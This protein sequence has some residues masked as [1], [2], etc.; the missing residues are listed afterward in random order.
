MGLSFQRSQVSGRRRERSGEYRQYF[1]RVQ[2]RVDAPERETGFFDGIDITMAGI[3]EL[4]RGEAPDGA[5]ELLSG[6]D[7][8]VADAIAAYSARNPAAVVPFLAQGLGAT[9]EAMRLS[10]GSAEALF[11]L[12]I[13]ERQFQ[14]AISA[15]MGIQFRAVASPRD[16]GAPQSPFAPLATM[17]PAVPGEPFQVDVSLVN[18]GSIPIETERTSL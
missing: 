12:A 13:K 2:S 14:D 15:A 6:I 17:G 16:S 11:L 3:Y 1:E 8:S 4:S 5:L 10:Q 18:P 9:R 7:E